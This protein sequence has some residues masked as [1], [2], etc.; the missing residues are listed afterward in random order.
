[1]S[2]VILSKQPPRIITTGQSRRVQ[3][4]DSLSPVSLLFGKD[5]LTVS[6]QKP[7]LLVLDHGTT[8]IRACVMNREG[9]FVAKGYKAFRQIFP[10]AGWVEHNPNTLW[11]TSL[12]V[13][14]Q[15]FQQ[16]GINWKDIHAV[17]LTNQRETV[18]L[19]DAKTGKPLHNAVVWQCRRT[20]DVCDQMKTSPDTVNT[21]VEKTGLVV[22]PYFSATKLKWLLDNTPKAKTLLEQ[23]RLR[24]GTVDTWILWNLSGGKVF[25]SD[26]TNASR[27]QL[28]NIHTKQWDPELLRLFGIPKEILPEVKGS[29]ETYGTVNPELTG[30][31]SV[32][33]AGCIGDQQA[34]LYGQK[35]WDSG[36]AK[37]TFGTGA[38]L[39]MNLADKPVRSKGGLLTT[40]A[41]QESGQ[42]SYASEGAVFTAGTILE[43]LRE[44]GILK[45]AKQA[46]ALVAKT[47][48]N[49]GVYFVPALTGLGAPHWEAHARGMIAGLTRKTDR[50]HLV[51]AALESIAYMTADVLHLMQKEAG[52]RLNSLRVDGGVTRSN[53]FMQ[54]LADMLGTPV[55]RVDD[56][57]ITAKG[58][59]FLAGLATGF[60]SSPQAIGELPEKLE[61]FQ[62]GMPDSEREERQTAWQRHVDAVLALARQ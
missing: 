20:A 25:V 14:D 18:M 52:L 58:A 44:V 19:W 60:F 57:E 56:A 15:A 33:L 21:I 1:M 35:C 5:T 46:D 48:G 41:C 45:S 30:G 47:R 40:L 26:L 23:G 55:T 17:G 36:S 16:A 37:S 6:R 53:F 4:S 9:Q 10:K 51:R 59:G 62:P 43:W 8:G 29:A 49:D 38:F 3:L 13:I 11:K 28:L 32:P 50:A 22:D 42:S 54:F 61:T 24:A 39:V 27:T 2:P 12:T 34:A 7:Y 31:E